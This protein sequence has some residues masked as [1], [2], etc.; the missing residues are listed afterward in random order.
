M[1]V[2]VQQITMWKTL[3]FWFTYVVHKTRVTSS[4]GNYFY[5]I[6][7]IF[8]NKDLHYCGKITNSY[9]YYMSFFLQQHL[10]F[11]RLYLTNCISFGQRGAI[12][13]RAYCLRLHY[14]EECNLWICNLAKNLLKTK[15]WICHLS[16]ELLI[17]FLVQVISQIILKS[18]FV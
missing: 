11:K 12:T 14:E 6:I 18:L 17:R 2:Y 8:L 10:Y 5:E 4:V 15:E 7:I 13:E 9:V 1:H 16:K 3:I